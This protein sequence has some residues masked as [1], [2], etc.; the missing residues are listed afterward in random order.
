[1]VNA[2]TDQV[3]MSIWRNKRMAIVE[4]RHVLDMIAQRNLT[5]SCNLNKQQKGDTA[6]TILD[7]HAI[8]NV[9]FNGFSLVI[10]YLNKWKTAINKTA[11]HSPSSMVGSGVAQTGSPADRSGVVAWGGGTACYGGIITIKLYK[12]NLAFI[13]FEIVLHFELFLWFYII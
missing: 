2:R 12:K 5:K 4:I 6:L 7:N 1:M 9:N 3:F 10:G 11:A 13:K 8:H